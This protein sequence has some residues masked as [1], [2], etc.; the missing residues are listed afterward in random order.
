MGRCGEEVIYGDATFLVACGAGGSRGEKAT[1]R[2]GNGCVA[3]TSDYYFFEFS[4]DDAAILA[5]VL[6]VRAINPCTV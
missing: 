4:V 2:G 3:S 1:P 5:G 6:D